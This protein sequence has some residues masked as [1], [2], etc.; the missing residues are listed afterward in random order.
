MKRSGFVTYY[1]GLLK[2]D[3][4]PNY[5]R[6]NDASLSTFMELLNHKSI[7]SGGKRSKT[8]HNLLTQCQ[9]EYR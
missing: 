8:F 5:P 2:S 4:Q 3:E 7:L 1:N 9:R 6:P